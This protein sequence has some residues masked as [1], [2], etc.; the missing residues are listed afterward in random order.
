MA[1]LDT[2]QRYKTNALHEALRYSSGERQKRQVRPS[3]FDATS[4]GAFLS[5]DWS[6]LTQMVIFG[7][8]DWMNAKRKSSDGRVLFPRARELCARDLL[9]S[10][11][12]H[13]NFISHSIASWGPTSPAVVSL[14]SGRRSPLLAGDTCELTEKR[15]LTQLPPSVAFTRS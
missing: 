11:A 13:F 3:P 15:P 4:T 14:L 8:S 5:F 9:Q 1:R 10:R 12:P 2:G 6:I 7:V